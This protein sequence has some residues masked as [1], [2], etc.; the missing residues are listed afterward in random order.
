MKLV[1]FIAENAEAALAQIQQ[2]LG[3]EAMVV[4]VRRLP[5]PGLSRLW[6]RGGNIEV[7]AC[8]PDEKTAPARH[9]V[10]P[11]VDA[12]VP[13]E[14]AIQPAPPSAP[15]RW[16]SIAW[17]ESLGLQRE[18]ADMLE[19]KLRELH[20][21]QPPL[22]PITQWSAVRD[23]LAGFWRPPRQTVEGTGRPHVF[24]GPSGTG[25]TTV[26]CKWMTAAVLTQQRLVKVWRLDGS[27]ANTSE[28]LTLHCEML[29][30]PAER[31]WTGVNE[32]ADLSFVDLPGIDPTDSSA[33]EV[34]R[35]QLAVLPQPH[36]HL[37]LNAAC[38]TSIL[39]E[40][41]R[42]FAA[43]APED[44]IFTHL[45]EELQRVKLWNFVLGTNLPL[46]FLSAGQKIPGNFCRAESVSL[47]PRNNPNK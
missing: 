28:F 2:Q 45:D 36:V 6:Q 22:S 39:F 41:V 15:H 32:P 29:G 17:L 23:V 40:Q 3:P 46:G 21:S 25:K 31:F 14:E 43:L 13:F 38:E 27:I 9:S 37:V 19:S 35:E 16:Q 47:F 12:Y 7:V 30:I 5:A 18:H 4:S 34:L 11:G 24:I 10:P 33:I 1:P 44:L 8:L 26:L 20:G 42:A